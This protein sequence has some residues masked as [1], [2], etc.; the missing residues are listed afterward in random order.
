MYFVYVVVWCEIER[1]PWHWYEGLLK[2][3][4]VIPKDD[5]DP[6]KP[7]LPSLEYIITA[8]QVVTTFF[9]QQS[10]FFDQF[11]LLY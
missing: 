8:G 11:F 6:I 4:D 5:L 2:A 3:P 1:I 10:Q 7:T 9:V